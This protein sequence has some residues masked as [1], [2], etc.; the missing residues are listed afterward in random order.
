MSFTLHPCFL[1]IAMNASARL[2]KLFGVATPGHLGLSAS[3]ESDPY[4]EPR[5]AA[6][7]LHRRAQQ[8]RRAFSA[9]AAR[10]GTLQLPAFV[11]AGE[12][13]AS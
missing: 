10:V 8:L 6:L 3:G 13:P 12:C 7:S 9:V 4:G 2:S 1:A 11:R 5:G